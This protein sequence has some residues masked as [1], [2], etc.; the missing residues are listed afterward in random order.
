M[1]EDSFKPTLSVIVP[2]F[3]IEKYVGKCIESI[4][5]QTYKNLE[6]IL[7]DDGSSDLSGVICDRYAK[8]DSRIKV[9]HKLNAG[10]VSA[11]K[12]GIM[13][14]TGDYA[15]YV[16][17][18]DWID[19]DMYEKLMVEMGDADV[20]VSGMIKEYGTISACVQNKIAPGV[21]YGEKLNVI[22][23][24]ML[25]TGKF[26]ESGIFVTVWNCI[27]RRQILLN[28]QICVPEQISM[29]EDAAC[30]VPVLLDSAKIVVSNLCGYHY[31][32]RDTSIVRT[33]TGTEL[34]SY[35]VLYRY[36]EKKFLS[37]AD[38][39][40]SLLKQLKYLM[41]YYLLMKE[42]DVL[43][44]ESN[45]IF[46]YREIPEKSQV[47]VYGKGVFGIELVNYLQKSNIM[48]IA[49]WV[50]GNDMDLFEKYISHNEYHYIIVAVLKIDIAK[51]IC[52][53]LLDRGIDK[54]KIRCVDEKLIQEGLR[55][56][57]TIFCGD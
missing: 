11:R 16:D 1:N 57:E 52:K 23:E 31:V 53:E 28:N 34:E 19:K 21:Y 33:K 26:F 40:D 50:D 38:F 47:I 10:L 36:L 45:K 42:L 44:D 56:V 15:A 43:Q 30:K 7:V 39:R 2:I 32:V 41:L 55:K 20:I 17:G 27:Y 48:N 25:Y 14:A 49:L 12:T 54:K 13:K 6:I 35:K 22:Y 4:M 51:M 18:D 8:Q 5:N 3:N 46:P 37:K 29:G 9:I 24:Q